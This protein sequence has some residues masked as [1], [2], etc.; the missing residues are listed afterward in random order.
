M[1]TTRSPV[2]ARS[3]PSG[4]A[5]CKDVGSLGLGFRRLP[6]SEEGVPVLLRLPLSL[7][8]AVAV[9]LVEDAEDDDVLEGDSIVHSIIADS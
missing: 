2:G 8:P 4:S 5:P 9:F 6:L 7:E 3:T 1:V